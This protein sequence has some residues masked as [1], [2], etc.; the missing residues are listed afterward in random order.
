MLK[1]TRKNKN[2]DDDCLKDTLGRKEVLLMDRIDRDSPGKPPSL[3][4][5]V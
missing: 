2:I 4:P 1:H 3:T 5:G